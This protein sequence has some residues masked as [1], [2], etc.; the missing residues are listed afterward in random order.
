M[1]ACSCRPEQA[2]MERPPTLTA[3]KHLLVPLLA[4]TKQHQE[5]AVPAR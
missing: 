1:L 4:L 5:P 3:L 2:G